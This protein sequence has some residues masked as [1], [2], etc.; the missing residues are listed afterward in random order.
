MNICFKTSGTTG[1]PK[2][3]EQP[4]KKLNAA[5][6]IA[7]YTQGIDELSKILTVCNTNHVGGALAQT[8][9]AQYVGARVDHKK[10]NPHTF[11]DD[12]TNYTHTH[13][14]PQ[15]I[16]MLLKVHGNNLGKVDLEG[17]F[18]T[19]GSDRV[20]KRQ[21]IPLLERG[22]TFMTNWGMTEVGPIAINTIFNSVEDV[23]RKIDW[24]DSNGDTLLGDKY[25]LKTDIQDGELLVRGDICVYPLWI[26]TGDMVEMRDHKR[27]VFKGRKCIR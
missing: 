6:N 21:M 26:H 8:H 4:Q 16:D 24:D 18:I 15:H 20:Y 1:S 2:V 14:V 7:L 10:F 13:L 11:L 27:M 5:A 19:C 25:W 9:P 3:I 17:V 12:V 23:H 22:A